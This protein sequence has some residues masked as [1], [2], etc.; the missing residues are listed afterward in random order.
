MW[1]KTI[2]SLVNIGFTRMEAQVYICL[3]QESPQS[4]YGVAKKLGKPAAYIYRAIDVLEKKGALLRQRGA[5]KLLRAVPY[6]ELINQLD[7]QFKTQLRS[8]EEGLKDIRPTDWDDHIYALSTVEQVYERANEMISRASG[9]IAVDLYPVP[10]KRLQNALE[11]AS[12][13]NVYVGAVVYEETD[14]AINRQVPS[15]A[16]GN[17]KSWSRQWLR[18]A[19]DGIEFMYA[20]LTADGSEVHDAIWSANPVQAWLAYY[21]MVKERRLHQAMNIDPDTGSLEDLHS[22]L[23]TWRDPKNV[24]ILP[25]MERFE[26][27]FGWR[28]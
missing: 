1:E 5:T 12:K 24:R 25:G 19:V 26:R 13:R 21:S 11:L 10:L 18:I 23:R 7:E 28:R 3:L 27:R 2:Q 9:G 14:V 6:N 22:L 20:L 4:G 16:E 8:A 17:V 15:F